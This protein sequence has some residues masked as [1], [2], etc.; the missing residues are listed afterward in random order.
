MTA[1]YEELQATAK[2]EL[3]DGGKTIIAQHHA[4]GLGTIMKLYVADSSESGFFDSTPANG[5]FDVYVR[6][7]NAQGVEEKKALGTIESGDT[8]SF[9][10]INNYGT[11][12]VEAF[13][14]SLEV[15]VED[16]DTSY[17]K[18]GNYLQ[19]QSPYGNVNCGEKG[20]SDS[21][22]QCYEDLG[23]TTAKVTMTNVSYT[24]I[25]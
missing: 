24:R 8:F 13:G 14:R 3:S 15:I 7:K 1:T 21:F 17:L 4:G 22:E 5:V 18:F 20:N 10:V 23:I 6:I 9:R 25:D 11:V 12:K 19:S 2:V 16:D